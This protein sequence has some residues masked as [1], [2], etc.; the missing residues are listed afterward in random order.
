MRLAGASLGRG[1][2]RT[3]PLTVDLTQ[4]VNSTRCPRS[5]FPGELVDA[6]L[7]GQEASQQ[8]GGISVAVIGAALQF[9][10]VALLGQQPSQPFGGILVAVI[11]ADPQLVDASVLG[12]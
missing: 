4:F 12:Q 7:L 6:A 3:V 11:G 1:S 8:S 2:G 5:H 10:D 9:V